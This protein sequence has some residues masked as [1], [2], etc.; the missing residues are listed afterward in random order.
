MNFWVE[1]VALIL[2]P[3]IAVG[4][5]LWRES[6]RQERERKMALM[7]Q[8]TIFRTMPGDPSFSTAINLVPIEFGHSDAVMTAWEAFREDAT[9]Q[10]VT[11]AHTND[12]VKAMLLDLGYSE[13]AASQIARTEYLANALGSQQELQQG[14][15]NGVLDIAKASRVSALAAVTM[16]EHVTGKPLVVPPEPPQPSQGAAVGSPSTTA[17]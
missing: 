14:V 17:K 1:I 8:L 2:G 7:R 15:L 12:V 11:P 10:R 5:S 4:L 6:K 9:R 13:R 16:A 3:A